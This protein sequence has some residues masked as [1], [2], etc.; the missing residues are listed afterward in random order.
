M[1]IPVILSESAFILITLFTR[2]C[3]LE[4]RLESWLPPTET[5]TP[6]HSEQSCHM[7]TSTACSLNKFNST[8]NHNLRNSYS[9]CLNRA[10][11]DGLY[12]D[13]KIICGKDEF[14][15]HKIIVCAQS[16]VFHAMCSGRFSVNMILQRLSYS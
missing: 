14:N 1:W 7:A 13:L 16:K 5:A 11:K 12:T 8:S 4:S 10:Y 6:T 3:R 2:Y 15:V 9:N